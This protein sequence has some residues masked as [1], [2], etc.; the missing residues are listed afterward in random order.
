MRRRAQRQ[1]K[2][3]KAPRRKRSTLQVA[4]SVLATKFPLICP[5]VRR[6][7][8]ELK[9]GRAATKTMVARYD[10]TAPLL[11]ALQPFLETLD[12][13]DLVAALARHPRLYWHP[14]IVKQLAHLIE[15][16]RDRETPPDLQHRAGNAMQDLMAA[17]AVGLLPGFRVKWTPRARPP[18]PRPGL[19][20]PHPIDATTRFIDAAQ[21]SVAW[22]ALHRAIA[23]RRL[24]ALLRDPAK[25]P[26]DVQHGV[27]ALA[28]GALNECGPLWSNLRQ[29]HFS[30]QPPKRFRLL[31]VARRASWALTHLTERWTVDLTSVVAPLVE[32]PPSPL[33]KKEGAP[34]FLAYAI[35]AI[36]LETT[37]ESVYRVIHHYWR[38]GRT[39]HWS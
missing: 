20:N 38:R 35:L 34:A 2:R 23:K 12:V 1:G 27:I 26:S 10:V 32:G 18:G 14:L 5:S 11:T 15:L 37:P 7:A 19:P 28:S 31:G 17:H 29:S 6:L 3:A 21:L 33:L 25:S 30:R 24:G 4:A 13:G 39:R 8:L 22:R 16:I 9:A 36:L